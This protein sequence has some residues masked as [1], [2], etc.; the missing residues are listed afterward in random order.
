MQVALLLV[1]LR[2]LLPVIDREQDAFAIESYKRAAAAAKSGAFA[3]ETVPVMVK[4]RKGDATAF[5][6]DEEIA[7]VDLSKVTTL[8][9]VFKTQGTITAANASS[10]SDGAS[11]LVLMSAAKAR[12]LGVVPLA[13]IRGFGDA[14][15]APIEFPTT[16]SLAVAIALKVCLILWHS[17]CDGCFNKELYDVSTCESP[18]VISY[19]TP[20]HPCLR[21]LE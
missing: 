2:P 6:H 14:E 4:G 3:W 9:P 18:L 12:S 15:Q 13:V 11:A 21:E 16:P 19:G 1:V 7:K 20:R 17:I 8:K 5:T 10:L